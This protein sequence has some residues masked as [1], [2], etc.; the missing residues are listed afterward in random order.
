LETV[1]RRKFRDAI[2]LSS[3]NRITI[4]FCSGGSGVSV[5]LLSAEFCCRCAADERA[6][7]FDFGSFLVGVGGLLATLAQ[8]PEDYT[9]KS[10]HEGNADCT[11]DDKA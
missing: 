5:Y 9:D 2:W 10:E 4:N 8:E 1:P 3:S 6:V 7:A 11:T